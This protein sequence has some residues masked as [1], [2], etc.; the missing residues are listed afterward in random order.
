MSYVGQRIKIPLGEIGLLTD[1][2]P[3]KMPPNA[4]IRA[5]NISL[6]NGSVEKAPGTLKWNATAIGTGLVAVYQ[7]RPSHGIERMIAVTDT[8]NI[9]K[10]QDR[11]FAQINSTVTSTLTPNCVFVEGGAE[12][13]GRDKKLFLF[14]DGQTNP[15]VLSGDGTAFAALSNPNTDWSGSR[16]PRAACVHRNRLWAFAGQIAYASD[17]GNHENFQTANLTEPVY[18]GE[19]GDI[20]G[21]FVYKG[22]LFAFKDG[23]FTY[24]LID[25]DTNESNWYWQKIASNFGI[26]A[27]NAI[28]EVLDDMVAGNIA[29]TI[30]SYA[31]SQKLGNVEAADL[32]QSMQFES[33]LRANTSKVG[34]P[35]QH[36]L[37]YSEKKLLLTTYRSAYYTYNDMLVVI[38]FGRQT[39]RAT[40]WNKG[41]PQCLA[42][43]KDVNQIE[44]PMYGDKDGYL[45]LM[46]Y[47]D[48][49]EGSTAY[50]GDFQIPH[51]DFSFADQGL[52]AVE[53][54][55]DF[56][57]VHY[58]PESSG[59][60]SCDYYIDGRFIETITF[61]MI[62]Y[63]RPEL[64]VLLLDTDRLAQGNSE[65]SIKRLRGT[66]RTFSAR[67]YN[68]G[69]N[70]SFQVPAITVYFRPGGDRAQKV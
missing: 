3:D 29:G 18:P 44:R 1:I 55:F 20:R 32:I 14:T 66:G 38:D 34:V 59:N 40:F 7:W 2:A 69:S 36:M 9:Y 63:Q 61:P 53:K 8:G 46:D 19:G 15:Y 68:S 39:P 43:Y 48:R 25:E 13:A 54:H 67:F 58:M 4:L 26:S 24:A 28:S 57:A 23:G 65:T 12:T 11:Q 62:Q 41:S 27:P 17:S 52:S 21:G 30:T 37:F 16:M 51:L 45:H 5:S 10:G 33:Y 70:Q 64:D 35:F 6:V 56:L 47:E 22:R 60:L 50:R 42:L 49:L 31:A